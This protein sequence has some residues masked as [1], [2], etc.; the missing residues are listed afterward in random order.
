MVQL[1]QV[2]VSKCPLIISHYFN[3]HEKAHD[4]RYS[5]YP[6]KRVWASNAHDSV[7]YNVVYGRMAQVGALLD[8][9]RTSR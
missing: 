5:R 6:A 9:G 7:W 3:C 8:L 4:P 2:S 1:C